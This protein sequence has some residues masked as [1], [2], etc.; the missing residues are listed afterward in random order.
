[1]GN[2]RFGLLAVAAFAL[3]FVGI[4]WASKGFPILMVRTVALKPDARIP[5]F[6]QVTRDVVLEDRVNSMTAQSDGDK[7]RDK[8]RLELWQAAIGYKLSPCDATMKK[9]LV[10]ALSNYTSA[11]ADIAG[12]HFNRCT[13]DG[14]RIDAARVA[15][16]TP[17]D[18]RVHQALREALEQGGVTQNDF[19]K[20]IRDNVF[21]FSGRIFGGPQ[22]SCMAKPR[23]DNQGR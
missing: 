14:D 6:H 23:A 20:S 15:F 19:P 17:A 7:S 1:M 21:L 16:K 11:W 9:N 12:C 3:A 18:I 22:E 13:G 8:L 2:S 5:T 10:A 4:S